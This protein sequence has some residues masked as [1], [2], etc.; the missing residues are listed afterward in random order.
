MEKCNNEEGYSN[1]DLECS[2]YTKNTNKLNKI[3]D[4]KV[5]QNDMKFQNTVF[6]AIRYEVSN[7]AAVAAIASD[8]K[9]T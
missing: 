3:K 7:T 1:S 4:F 2:N 9:W 8:I 6:A 5:K